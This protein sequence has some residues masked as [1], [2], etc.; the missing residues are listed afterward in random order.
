MEELRKDQIAFFHRK[1]YLVID[2]LFANDL[3]HLR[4][5][6]DDCVTK[7]VEKDSNMFMKG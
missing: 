2:S 3:N 6:C 4:S 7:T 1:G 5:D